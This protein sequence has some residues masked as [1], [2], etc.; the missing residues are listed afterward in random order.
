MAVVRAK[1]AML[2]SD[3][4]WKQEDV[5]FVDSLLEPSVEDDLSRITKKAEFLVQQ[6]IG[7]FSEER[8][9]NILAV[10]CFAVEWDG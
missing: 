3:R 1:V 10:K 8:P 5:Y 7:Y 9:L 2:K 6:K 4:T